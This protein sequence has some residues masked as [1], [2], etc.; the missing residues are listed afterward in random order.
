MISEKDTTHVSKFLSMVLRHQPEIIG[1]LLDENGWT[2]VDHLLEQ[3][4]ANGFAIS[5]STLQYVV[6]TN[7]KKRFALSSDGSKIRASQGHSVNIALDYGPQQPP[8]V[9]YHGTAERSLPSIL[10]TGLDKRDRHH[11]HLSELA[12]TAL[13]VGKRY[14]RPVL[15]TVQAQRMFRD[16]YTFFRSENGVWLTE[17]VPVEYLVRH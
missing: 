12:E 4:N 11:V 2:D 9:L 1:L 7:D 16:G 14:G 17:H 13:S 15:L 3:M 10:L 8:D 6:E 5:F